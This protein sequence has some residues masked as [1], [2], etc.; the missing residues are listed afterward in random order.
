[1][2][3]PKLD[4]ILIYMYF[5]LFGHFSLSFTFSFWTFFCLCLSVSLKV[6][7]FLALSLFLGRHVT[8]VNK[9]RSNNQRKKGGHISV[10]IRVKDWTYSFHKKDIMCISSL[11]IHIFLSLNIPLSLS[12][13]LS[14]FLCLFLSLSLCLNQI[15]EL[16]TLYR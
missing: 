15:N 9:S 11:F 14:L 7:V 8:S 10:D 1:M 5:S 4:I 12:L 6:S 13:C 16:R 3:C 2:V